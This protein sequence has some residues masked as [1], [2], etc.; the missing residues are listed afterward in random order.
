LEQE[1][2]K[3]DAALRFTVRKLASEYV[4]HLENKGKRRSALDARNIFKN[5]LENTEFGGLPAKELTSK[6]ASELVRRT[7]EA[8]HGR[9]AIKFRAYLRAAYTLA[10]SA[11]LDPATP[12]R[13]IGFD[14]KANPVADVPV[15]SL[16]EQFNQVRTRTLSQDELF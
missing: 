1:R 5:H 8:G 11:D 7:V 14:L 4:T 16:A 2:A 9:T 15:K 3:A 13:F 10:L 12:S 6:N